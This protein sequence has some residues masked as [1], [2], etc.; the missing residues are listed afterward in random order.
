MQLTLRRSPHGPIIT[1]V[2][3]MILTPASGPDGL[4]V[5]ALTAAGVGPRRTRRV[6]SWPTAAELLAHTGRLL[7]THAGEAQ[8]MLAWSPSLRCLPLPREVT[9]IETYCP[10]YITVPAIRRLAS[11]VA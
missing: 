3:S 4:A 11:R 9:G 6:D 2:R 10:A 8:R 7:T 5:A 1:D